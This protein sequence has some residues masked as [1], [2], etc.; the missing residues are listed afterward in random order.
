MSVSLSLKRPWEEDTAAPHHHQQHLH[1][2]SAVKR[3]RRAHPAASSRS[4]TSA[5]AHPAPAAAAPALAV[6]LAYFPDMD[7][8]VGQDEERRAL[9]GRGLN[10]DWAAKGGCWSWHHVASTATSLHI[11]SGSLILAFCLAFLCM[12]CTPLCS[13][14]IRWLT[15]PTHPSLYAAIQRLTGLHLHS[16]DATVAAATATLTRTP[17]DT[18]PQAPSL[19]Q[20]DQGKHRHGLS[21]Q[22]QLLK[23]EE[24]AAV[25]AVLW[26]TCSMPLSAHTQKT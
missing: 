26:A 19:A 24:A 5:Y 20:H 25:Q 18:T 3:A 6:L 9:T 10:R 12:E 4:A 2:T 21:E 7:E 16:E 14:L 1:L 17:Q 15:H 11:P 13:L 23:V 22:L 8:K